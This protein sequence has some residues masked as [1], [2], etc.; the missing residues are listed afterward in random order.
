MIFRPSESSKK[1]TDFY[2]RYLLTTFSTNNEKYN[3]QLK[4]ELEKSKAL[5]DGP[6]IRM[7][8]P[9][10][11]GNKIVDLVKTGILSKE[12]LKLNQFH[13]FDRELY[14]HQE[15]AIIK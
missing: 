15:E 3:E 12:F 1:I 14:K 7:S 6:Y 8:D 5:A 4:R 2:R 11:R 9:F 13:P 10:K